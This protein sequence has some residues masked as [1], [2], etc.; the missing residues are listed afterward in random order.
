MGEFR[1]VRVNRNVGVMGNLYG[2]ALFTGAMHYALCVLLLAAATAGFN[3]DS[4]D[5][6][7][8]MEGFRENLKLFVASHVIEIGLLF[9]D[10]SDRADG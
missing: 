6:V 9:F 4:A 7:A 8:Q 10:R 2:W 1:T 3:T 5:V